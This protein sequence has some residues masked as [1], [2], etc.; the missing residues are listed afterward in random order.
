MK[1]GRARRW[2]L[3]AYERPLRTTSSRVRALII[4]M[5]ERAKAGYSVHEAFS[6]TGFST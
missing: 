6:A 3:F 1:L 5:R 4:L 2:M